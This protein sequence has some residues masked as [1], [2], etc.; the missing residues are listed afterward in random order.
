MREAID[1]GRLAET[2]INHSQLIENNRKLTS[3][4]LRC[5]LA[6]KSHYVPEL[7]GPQ[8]VHVLQ[9]NKRRPRLFVLNT[10]ARAL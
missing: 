2:A 4:S 8:C 5:F 7:T 3:S 6:H 1:S 9:R 10:I